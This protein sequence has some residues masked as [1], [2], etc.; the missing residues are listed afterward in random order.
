MITRLSCLVRLVKNHCQWVRNQTMRST[1]GKTAVDTVSSGMRP[2]VHGQ[3]TCLS[4]SKRVCGLLMECTISVETVSCGLRV[5]SDWSILDPDYQTWLDACRFPYSRYWWSQETRRHTWHD[6]CDGGAQEPQ[7]L[8]HLFGAH[9]DHTHPINKLSPT[10]HT[11]P[12]E[13]V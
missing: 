8:N 6:C 13:L 5:C 11:K 9:W 4:G 1:I 10:V 7:H 12:Q 3:T 2:D